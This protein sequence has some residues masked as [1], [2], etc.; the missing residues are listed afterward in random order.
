MSNTETQPTLTT[1]RLILRPFVLEDASTVQ[2]LAGDRAVADTTERIPHPYEDGMAEAW[3]ATH[4]PQFRERKECTFAIVLKDDQQV[5][6]G[7]SLTLTMAHSRGELGYWVGREFWNRGYCTEAARAIVEYGFSVLGLNRIQ[8]RHLTRNPASG[9]VMAKLG[10]Q[11]E[12]CL[13]QHTRKWDVFEDVD[14]YGR[15]SEVKA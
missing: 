7:V 2:R 15:I 11:H 12:G 9:C 13:R 3:I 6:G 14:L 8:A 5:I 1:E 4:A 10:M